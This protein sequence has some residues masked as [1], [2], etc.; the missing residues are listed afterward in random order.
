MQTIQPI[1]IENAE[2]PMLRLLEMVKSEQSAFF[3]E[4]GQLCNMIQTM[5]RA[6]RAME[7][8]LQFER[9]LACGKLGSRLAEQIALAVAQANV[10]EYSLARHASVARKLGLSREEIVASR[11][12]HGSTAK[13]AAALQFAYA[14]AART[15]ESSAERLREVGFSE[16][17]IVE[18]VAH[19][20]LNMFENYFNLVARTD[21]DFP[22]A[23]LASRAAS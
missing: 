3:N 1:R 9:T 4:D 2:G 17:E 22:R 10:C 15:G 11:E 20:S 16:P 5:A 6:P 14:L 12:A 7:G 21:L 8:Y 19:V 23:G 18:I 13:A